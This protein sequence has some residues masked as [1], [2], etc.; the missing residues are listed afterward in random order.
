M[1]HLIYIFFIIISHTI[2]GYTD[3]VSNTINQINLS[4]V[5]SSSG[6]SFLVAGHAYGHPSESIYPSQSLINYSDSIN[7]SNAY[8]LMLLGDNYRLANELNITT[9][10]Q[11][12]LNKIKI[13]VFNAVGNHD[14]Y[15]SNYTLYKEHFT[16]KT[17]Y[18]FIINSSLFIVL[19]TELEI[20]NGLT[21]GSITGDQLL[22][23][24]ETLNQFSEMDSFKTKN[25][26]IFTHKE[27][28]LYEDNNYEKEVMP[29][30]NA[31]ATKQCNV[32]VL[33][34][35]MKKSKNELYTIQD[36]NSYLQYIH[37][38]LSDNKKDKILN[39]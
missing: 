36:K 23:L 16:E 19:D 24:K 12:F 1:K 22:F 8:F 38:H 10:K 28:N 27:L 6:F 37:T 31:I 5:N 14:I 3:T 34:G 35:D 30:V 9:F 20:N 18:S 33:S 29:L 39:I 21:N 11:S 2:F 17:Y 26:F 4:P 32:Y 25:I 13:P 7:S 15:P